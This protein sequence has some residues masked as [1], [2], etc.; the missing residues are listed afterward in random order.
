ME[1]SRKNFNATCKSGVD[2]PLLSDKTFKIFSI[3]TLSAPSIF[4]LFRKLCNV[5]PVRGMAQV[6]SKDGFNANKEGKIK[7]LRYE[8]LR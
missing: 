5:R 4:N 2:M 6:M 1:I 3:S 7:S 8:I